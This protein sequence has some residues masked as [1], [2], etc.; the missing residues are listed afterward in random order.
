[1]RFRN[2][3]LLLI[4]FALTFS[5][6]ACAY[7]AGPA[8]GNGEP[9]GEGSSSAA[10]PV[11]EPALDP[12]LEQYRTDY[13]GDASKVS[14]L[15]MHLDYPEGFS[16][17]HIEIWSEAAPYALTVCLKGTGSIDAAG[18]EKFSRLAD[19]AFDLIGN[20]DRIEF[21]FED[22]AS[23][24]LLFDRYYDRFVSVDGED[25]QEIRWQ[26]RTYVPYCAIE[27][28][29]RG[30]KLGHIGED[31]NDEVYAC[32][33]LAPEEWL[34]SFYHSGLM[35]NGMLMREVSVMDI[36]E[37]LTSEYWWNTPGQIAPYEQTEDGLWESRGKTY[38]Y[39]L[40][41]TGRLPN[42]AM[43]S[44]YIVLSN[45]EDITFEETAES[46]YSSQYPTPFSQRDAV[47]VSLRAVEDE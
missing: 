45:E 40:V 15:A 18:R 23:E 34:I 28:S 12:A 22:M 47:L 3:V 46:L 14:Q 20:M 24:P 39:R 36:P 2:S 13:I 25:Y 32:K 8:S 31:E 17:D 9:A 19:T 6:S 10:E 26:G 37:G 4:I 42:A 41:L 29:R 1:M 30:E 7:T 21:I 16:Y 44:E 35:D 33:G 38:K 11:S 27:N 5:V 43:D